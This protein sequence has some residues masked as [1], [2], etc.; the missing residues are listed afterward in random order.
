MKIEKQLCKYIV[1]NVFAMIGTSCYILADTWFISN[2]AGTDGITALNL[3]LPVYGLIFAIGSMIGIGS[4]I[5][6]SLCKNT[7]RREADRYF[8]NAVMWDII[9]GLLFTTAGIFV[10]EY[11]IRFMG[12]D[13][14][15]M[16]VGTPYLRVALIFAPFFMMNYAFTAFVR[17]DGVPRVAM[18]AT[19][20]S[21]L[22]NIVFDYL[23]MFPF[24]M[25]MVGAALATG[26]SPIVSIL[27]CLTHFFSKKNN[28]RFKLAVPSVKLF[29]RSCS[30][31]VVAFVGEIASGITTMVFNF[32]LLGLAG[33]TAVAAYG[34][35]ANYALV[36]T[37]VFNGVSQGMQPLASEMH[38]KGETEAKKRIIRCATVIGIILSV[39]IVGCVWMFAGSCVRIFNGEN[40]RELADYAV[41]GIRIYFAG[42]LAAAVNIIWAGYFSATGRVVPAS[43]V[44][45]SRGI[46]AIIVFA[47][48]LSR[49]LGITGVWLAFPCAEVFTLGITFIMNRVKI[50]DYE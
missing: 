11:I 24:G 8:S 4:A 45:F 30:T 18:A 1:L 23:F 42:F 22:F 40:S 25:G 15:I 28:I 47:F 13:E 27:I 16:G 6:Y 5:R 35:V 17:N 36:G 2:A 50:N 43:V 14:E 41:G 38:G 10:P 7:K 33:N 46:I 19:L 12:A 32:I 9:F 20:L 49:V 39:L 31:G 44:A 3:T 29:I 48:I 21:S 34:V 37:A 26:I